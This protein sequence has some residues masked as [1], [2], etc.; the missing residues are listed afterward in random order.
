MILPAM[1]CNMLKLLTPLAISVLAVLASVQPG[2]AEVIYPW[3]AQYSGRAGGTNCGFVSYEQ[4]RATVS[5]VGGYCSLNPWYPIEP[6][7]LI[8]KPRR[9]YG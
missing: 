1:E 2:S 8:R 4:C 9:T 5:G 6:Q 3:C 7:P